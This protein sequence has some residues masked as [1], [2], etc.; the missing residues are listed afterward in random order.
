[1]LQRTV[2]KGNGAADIVFICLRVGRAH[3]ENLPSVQLSGQDMSVAGVG[4]LPG[5]LH[6]QGIA[7]PESSFGA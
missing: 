7:F 6:I 3:A 4:K 1:M 5:K 2:Q